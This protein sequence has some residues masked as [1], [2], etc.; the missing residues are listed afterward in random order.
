MSGGRDDKTRVI[1]FTTEGNLRLLQSNREWLGDG[2]FDLAPKRV[3]KQVYTIHIIYKNKDLPMVYGLLPNKT[4]KT[5]KKF[6]KMIKDVIKV[7]PL[8]YKEYELFD[9]LKKISHILG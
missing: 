4:Q 3:F 8:D 1:V 7:L 2:T 9:Y 6:F 5:Y